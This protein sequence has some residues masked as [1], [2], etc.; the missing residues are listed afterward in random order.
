MYVLKQYASTVE[1]PDNNDFTQNPKFF[2]WKFNKYY[3]TLDDEEFL[4]EEVSQHRSDLLIHEFL[5]NNIHG[6]IKYNVDHF[7]IRTSYGYSTDQGV[8]SRNYQ[9]NIL[10]WN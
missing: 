4:Y 9:S 3:R 1:I 8:F 7:L 2:E 6:N 5:T 10:G